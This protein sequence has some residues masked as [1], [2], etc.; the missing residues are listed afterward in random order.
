MSS[1]NIK[2]NVY[3]NFEFWSGDPH[4]IP[5]HPGGRVGLYIPHAVSKPAQTFTVL[6]WGEGIDGVTSAEEAVGIA[7]K[8]FAQEGRHAVVKCDATWRAED[9]EPAEDDAVIFAIATSSKELRKLLR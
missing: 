1:D 6:W 7:M 4:S 5:G 3:W 2:G 9:D 8:M